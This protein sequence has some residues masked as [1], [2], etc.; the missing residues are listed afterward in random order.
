MHRK[1]AIAFHMLDTHHKSKIFISTNTNDELGYNFE[2]RL[3]RIYTE[4]SQLCVI[5]Y[6]KIRKIFYAYT[7]VTKEKVFFFHR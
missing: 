1:C 4:S 7:V 2:K 3:S 5:V 6:I